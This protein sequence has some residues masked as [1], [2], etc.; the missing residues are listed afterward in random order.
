[1]FPPGEVR[2]VTPWR[3]VVLMTPRGVPFWSPLSE[4]FHTRYGLVTPL[5]YFHRVMEIPPLEDIRREWGLR[6]GEAPGTAHL[7]VYRLTGILSGL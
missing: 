7:V 4:N 3:S 6:G 2:A 5:V 1:V